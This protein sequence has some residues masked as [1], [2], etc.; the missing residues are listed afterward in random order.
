MQKAEHLLFHRC[1]ALLFS[2]L[3]ICL[4]A[5]G[6][7]PDLHGECGCFQPFERELFCNSPL[8]FVFY[9]LNRLSNQFLVFSAAPDT[10][11]A[12]CCTSWVSF[13]PAVSCT[14]Q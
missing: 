10:L 12:A 14:D 9:Q 4:C 13:S 1:S 6:I 8:L 2:F 11:D 3:Q 7:L 5:F